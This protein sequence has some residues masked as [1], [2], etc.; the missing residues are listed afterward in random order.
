M[1]EQQQA[2]PV[3]EQ[4]PAPAG[5]VPADG[6]EALREEGKKA[7]DIWKQRAKQAEAAQ[8]AAEAKALQLEES[9][10]LSESERK[11]LEARRAIESEALAKANDRILRSEVRAAAAAKLADPADALTFLDL[12]QFQVGDDGDVDSDAI[13]Q[14]IDGLLRSKPYL[15]AQS[16]AR[17]QGTADGGPRNGGDAAAGPKQLTRDDMRR[18]DSAQIDAAL[19]A[20]QFAD[21]LAGKQ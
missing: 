9:Q 7:L 13:A 4:D 19:T 8:R 12:T 20:G 1:T 10:R 5:P 14:A 6:D 15:S 17:F 11:A 18:M 16:Q 3:A 21:L 2:A